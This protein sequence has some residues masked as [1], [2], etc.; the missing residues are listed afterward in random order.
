M[1]NSS[2]RFRRIYPDV[3]APAALELDLGVRSQA[4]YLLVWRGPLALAMQWAY[5]LPRQWTGRD[6]RRVGVG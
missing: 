1:I 4:A 3:F 2:T 5:Q 6:G